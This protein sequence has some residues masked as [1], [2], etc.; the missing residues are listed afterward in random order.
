MDTRL[1]LARRQQAE[2]QAAQQRG[3]LNGALVLL[4]RAIEAIGDDYRPPD[5]LD[6]TPMK[7]TLSAIE[8]RQGKLDTATALRRGVLESRIGMYAERH[9]PDGR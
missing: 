6:D 8:Q 3:D 2:A 9:C 5:T 1:D 7:L 4:D